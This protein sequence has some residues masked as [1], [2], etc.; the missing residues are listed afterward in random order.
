H[1]GPHQLLLLFEHNSKIALIRL[2]LHPPGLRRSDDAGLRDGD[3]HSGPLLEDGEAGGA[4]GM[5]DVLGKRRR[6]VPFFGL[7]STPSRAVHRPGHSAIQA[8]GKA[9]EGHVM[10]DLLASEADE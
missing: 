9:N 4:S 5:P 3:P 7:V 6:E 1:P 10:L 2:R 8:Y